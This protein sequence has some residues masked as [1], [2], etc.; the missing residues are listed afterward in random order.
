MRYESKAM[1]DIE[2]K[3]LLQVLELAQKNFNP[4]LAHENMYSIDQ[5]T[6]EASIKQIKSKPLN[7]V[8]KAYAP[9]YHIILYWAMYEKK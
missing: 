1:F 8:W 3:Y 4:D 9:Y 7:C 5:D 6:I 2:G